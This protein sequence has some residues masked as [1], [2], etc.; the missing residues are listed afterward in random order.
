MKKYVKVIQIVKKQDYVNQND[1]TDS[2]LR[3]LYILV[4]SA[5][6]N[7]WRTALCV[8]IRLTR[9]KHEDIST[10]VRTAVLR[11]EKEGEAE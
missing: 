1:H 5:I 11:C 3:V 7:T 6:L 8:D 10:T 9:E 4:V 2:G